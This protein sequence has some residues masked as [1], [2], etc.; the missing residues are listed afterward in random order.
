MNPDGSGR[1]R[2]P[3]TDYGE[4]PSWSPDGKRIAFNSNLSGEALM[5]IID[6]AGSRVVHL[7]RVGRAISSL[8]RPTGARTCSL[9]IEITRTTPTRSM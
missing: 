6:V 1:R 7:S 8:R 2:L 3:H 9:R 4:D 5:Y